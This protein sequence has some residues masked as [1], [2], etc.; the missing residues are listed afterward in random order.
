MRC[1]IREFCGMLA[2]VNKK[3]HH[4]KVAVAPESP[5]QPI[6]RLNCRTEQQLSS[7]QCQKSLQHRVQL[8]VLSDVHFRSL[9]ADALFAEDGTLELRKP[10]VQQA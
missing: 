6:H 4:V 5:N 10:G 1:C 8:L 3:L 9:L 7:H 2:R